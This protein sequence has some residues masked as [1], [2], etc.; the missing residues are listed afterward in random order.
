MNLSSGFPLSF[1]GPLNL[2]FGSPSTFFGPYRSRLRLAEAK[3]EVVG[4]NGSGRKLA[5]GNEETFRWQA[6]GS[7]KPSVFTAILLAAIVLLYWLHSLLSI[8]PFE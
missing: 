5:A 2:S 3:Q 4:E 8:P 6:S 7:S 1:L